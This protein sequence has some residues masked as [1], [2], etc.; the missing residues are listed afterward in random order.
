MK[1]H[2]SDM[3]SVSFEFKI[4][5]F[6]SLDCCFFWA[7]KHQTYQTR[8]VWVF[9]NWKFIICAKL[10][11]F[12]NFNFYQTWLLDNLTFEKSSL[13]DLAASLFKFI[14]IKLTRLGYW[15]VS[16]LNYQN[17]PDLAA[18][19]FEIKNIHIVS[20]LAACSFEFLKMEFY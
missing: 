8:F 11:E 2:A 10:F 4:N 16:V 6:I 3:V 1:N 13:S 20:E 5:Q 12:K 18:G 7:S 17:F 9:K 14:I 15:F 19:K